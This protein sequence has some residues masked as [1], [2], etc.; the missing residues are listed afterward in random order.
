MSS[1]DAPSANLSRRNNSANALA[2]SE[3][4]T[5]GLTT[6]F[7][8]GPRESVIQDPAHIFVLTQLPLMHSQGSV[9]TFLLWA[10]ADSYAI[11]F[12]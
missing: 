12:W 11:V 9:T 8:F 2:V 1:V 10:A 7:P 5:L 3:I 4:I 6:I